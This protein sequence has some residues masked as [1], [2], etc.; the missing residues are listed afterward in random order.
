MK[1]AHFEDTPLTPEQIKVCTK[2]ATTEYNK[3]PYK[4]YAKGQYEL[5][6]PYCQ[7]YHR[8]TSEELKNIR[9]KKRCPNCLERFASTTRDDNFKGIVY[10][11]IGGYGYK[12]VSEWKFGEPIKLIRYEQ[13]AAFFG[14]T[15]IKTGYYLGN[16]GRGIYYD[17]AKT[18]SDYYNYRRSDS[19]NYL[20]NMYKYHDCQ[21]IYYYGGDRKAKKIMLETYASFITKSNQKKILMDYCVPPYC[22]PFIKLFDLNSAEDIFKYKSYMKSND[23]EADEILERNQY[24]FNKYYLDYLYRNGIRLHDYISYAEKLKAMGMKLDKPSDFK[25]RDEIVSDMYDKYKAENL[26]K[27]I[28]KRYESLP[29]YELE[30]IKIL[31]FKD[32]DEMVT[33]GKVLHNCIGR[34]YVESYA[35]SKT[36]VYHLDV[37]DKMTIAIE[38]AKGKLQQARSDN[39]GSCPK[40]LLEHIKSFC[41]ANG[42]LLGYY[43]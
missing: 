32:K 27:L 1:L 42:F 16:F 37:D 40:N 33:C 39:N 6:C 24:Q 11:Y 36:D 29:K 7:T 20:C 21:W 28:A 15:Y 13:I 43:A 18:K 35:E 4:K 9:E 41:K 25:M 2:L 3:L 5:Y 12:F 38:I 26:N 30:N 8:I 34:M 17:E 10:V 23:M 14:H 22:F 31:P 19:P